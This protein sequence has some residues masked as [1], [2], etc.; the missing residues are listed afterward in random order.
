[1]S[2]PIRALHTD[3]GEAAD[4]MMGFKNDPGAGRPVLIGNPLNRYL[5]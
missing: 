5:P 4:V 1:M 3:I 2:T